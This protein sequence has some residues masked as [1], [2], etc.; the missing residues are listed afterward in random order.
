MEILSADNICRI[1][2]RPSGEPGSYAGIEMA[3]HVDIGHG[4]FEARN[5]DIHFLNLGEFVEEFDKFISDRTRAPRLNGTYDSHIS[6]RASGLDVVCE[7]CVGDAFAGG[8]RPAEFFQSGKFEIERDVL[9]D[10]LRDFR[11]LLE[12]YLR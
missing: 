12:Q 10:L 3:A 1:T 4:R 9:L 8:R 2:L 7:Y 5:R 11:Q 6:F